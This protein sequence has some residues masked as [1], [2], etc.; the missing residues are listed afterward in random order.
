MDYDEIFENFAIKNNFRVLKNIGK[1][2]FGVVKEIALNGKLLAAKLTKQN[3]LKDFD[4][5]EIIN[6]IRGP[7]IVKITKTDRM[8]YNNEIYDLLIMEKGNLKDLR[9]FIHSIHNKN[10]LQLI[11]KEPFNLIGDNLL[12]YFIKQYLKGMEILNLNNYSHFDIKPQNYLIFSNLTLKLIDFDLLRNI[13]ENKDK[14]GKF[15]MPGGTKGYL[16]PEFYLNDGLLDVKTAMKQDFFC[17]GANIFYLKYGNEMFKYIQL[18]EGLIN[19]DILVDLLEKSIDHIKSQELS[20][21]EFNDFLIS[22]INYT[23]EERP[24]FEKIYRNKWV[25]KYSDEINQIVE[26]NES[27][28]ELKLI[29]ELD[30]SDF[31][32]NKRNNDKSTDYSCKENNK[33]KIKR[34][35]FKFN[36]K[37]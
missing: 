5:S 30:K 19:S 12:R 14:N 36:K 4:Q 8:I 23:P 26:I 9:I 2:G 35:K 28:D 31:L 1:G 33:N 25:N 11:F 21:T 13:E 18:N 37:K 7:G 24:E 32:I 10:L 3:N 17:L 29:I 16:S 15:K 22:L 20:D 34:H 6:N 27:E